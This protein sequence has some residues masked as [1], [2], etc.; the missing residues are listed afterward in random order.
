MLINFMFIDCSSQKTTFTDLGYFVYKR[1][2]RL[3]K[4]KIKQIYHTWIPDVIN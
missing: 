1:N 4:E 2:E 3:L